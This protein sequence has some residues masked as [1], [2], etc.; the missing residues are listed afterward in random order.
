MSQ[1]PLI[2]QILHKQDQILNRVVGIEAGQEQ[3]MKRLESIDNR[4]A[5]IEVKM[6]KVEKWVSLENA[7]FEPKTA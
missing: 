6:S 5:N 3:V 4:L 2:N 1:D 7:D